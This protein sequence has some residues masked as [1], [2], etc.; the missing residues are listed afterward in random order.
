MSDH[1]LTVFHKVSGYYAHLLVKE[2]GKK[3][4]K[5]DIGFTTENKEEYISFN[6]KINVNLAGATNKGGKKVHKNI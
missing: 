1:V 3:L 2:L 6:V 4:I 5:E